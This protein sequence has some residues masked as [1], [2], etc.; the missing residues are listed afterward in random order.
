MELTTERFGQLTIDDSEII[1]FGSGLPAFETVTRFVVLRSADTEPFAWLQAVDRPELAFLLLNPWDFCASYDLDIG[2]EDC[3]ELG[4]TGPDEALIYAI[5]TITGNR[6]QMTANL[7]APVVIN[8]MTQ[9]GK[10]VINNLKNYSIRH[11]VV[12]DRS[13]AESRVRPTIP[14]AAEAQGRREYR[15]QVGVTVTR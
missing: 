8:R 12:E 15:G 2:E 5:L 4:L 1:T 6:P 3:Q 10:Q 13:K 14:T 9:K 7:L 11:P